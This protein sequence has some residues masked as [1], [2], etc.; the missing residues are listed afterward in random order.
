MGLFGSSG[1]SGAA[2]QEA[3]RQANISKGMTDI[4]NQFSGFTPSFYQNAASDYTKATTPQMMSDYRNTKN[5]LTYSLARAGILNS[6]AATQRNNSLNQQL[7]TNESQIANN[8]QGQSNTLQANVNTQKGQLVN[9]LEASA[10][11]T[12]I[13]EQANA[14]T[15][16]LRAPS[17]IQPLGNLFADWTQQYLAG[18]E[19][20]AYNQNQN[21]V[22][23]NMF[24]GQGQNGGGVGSSIMVQ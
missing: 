6:G 22:W 8:A 4:N 14:A 10:D 2:A 23:A 15:S 12:S 3:A 19:S 24:G 16:Q 13:S 1:D 18:M 17:A 11:P 7:S 21:N 5:N 20:N 9:Q